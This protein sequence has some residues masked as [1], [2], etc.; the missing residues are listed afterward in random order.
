[1]P[2]SGRIAPRDFPPYFLHP[3]LN[4]QLTQSEFDALSTRRLEEQRGICPGH[5]LTV[6]HVTDGEKERRYIVEV[7]L[8]KGRF[9]IEAPCT[10]TPS[11]G[12]DVL[13]GNLVNDAEEWI[14]VQELKLRPRR[15]R[16]IFGH[17]HRLPYK[18]YIRVVTALHA[19][20][21]FQDVDAVFDIP[22]APP[23]PIA[24]RKRWW[25]FWGK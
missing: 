9:F 18:D 10:F 5:K 11:M 21:R 19:G 17:E 7:V 12:L 20:E 22:E 4:E 1:M 16:H 3:S 15:L 25:K 8:E 13:D 23:P 2:N 6:T 14:L 24:Q